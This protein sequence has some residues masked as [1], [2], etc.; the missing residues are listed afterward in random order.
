RRSR[1]GE[2]GRSQDEKRSCGWTVLSRW[3][4]F[5]V[6]A[7]LP[8]CP[9]SRGQTGRSAPT[10]WGGSGPDLARL[11]VGREDVGA[12][13]FA[14]PDSQYR[15]RTVADAPAHADVEKNISPSKCW[16]SSPCLRLPPP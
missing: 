13:G 15:P 14:G 5:V 7:D 9:G 1:R 12:G 4:G 6:G 8:V 10:T 16:A 3:G 2:P 11:A